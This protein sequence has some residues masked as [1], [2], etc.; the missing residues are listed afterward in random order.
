MS[1]ARTAFVGIFAM[2]GIAAAAIGMLSLISSGLT[3]NAT[4]AAR[5]AREGWAFAAGGLALLAAAFAL[6]SLS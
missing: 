1:L 3:A 2:L 6:R 5:E 4:L